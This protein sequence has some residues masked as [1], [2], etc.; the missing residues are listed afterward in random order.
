MFLSIIIP[1]FNCEK[2]IE[3]CLLSIINQDIK[4]K[5]YEIICINDGSSDNSGEII[6]GYAKKYTNLIYEEQTN[7]GVSA[8]RNL[9]MKF[10]RGE[11]VW[12]IDADDFVAPDCFSE[13]MNFAKL[14]D[15]DRIQ[16]ASYVFFEKLN[17][18]EKNMLYKGNLKSNYPYKDVMATRTL[19]KRR[20][21]LENCISFLEGIDY[22]ED[23]IFNYKTMLYHPKTG[24]SGILS[25]L[26]RKHN[27]SATA[28]PM[29]EMM[30]KSLSDSKIVFNELVSDYNS[31]ICIKESRRML[32]YWMKAIINDYSLL[33]SNYFY[34]MFAWEYEL[35][36]IP[37]Y[38]FELKKYY[39]NI[40]HI[41]KSKDYKKLIKI[42]KKQVQQTNRSLRRKRMCKSF[43]RY[44]KHPKRL[45]HK[46]FLLMIL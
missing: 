46:I 17:N 15:F 26:Y 31:R 16:V 6:L 44:I 11:F 41:S 9:G 7:K 38:D 32:L 35:N 22:G 34:D 27:L 33:D 19:Y 20:Y 23:G 45:F 1:V 36:N 3:E 12:F 13:L 8:A 10:A 18:C 30:R 21:L 5:E 39:K 2:Y 37:F 43:T 4:E 40:I 42:A 24:D 28:K 14:H 25:Y 29:M